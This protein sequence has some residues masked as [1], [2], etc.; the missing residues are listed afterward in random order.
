MNYFAKKAGVP[1]CYTNINPDVHTFVK[2]SFEEFDKR[3]K[4]ATKAVAK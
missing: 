1:E 4:A 3:A 2:N